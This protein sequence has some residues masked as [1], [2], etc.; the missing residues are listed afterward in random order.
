MQA[1]ILAAAV[2]LVLA[3]AP[4]AAAEGPTTPPAPAPAPAADPFARDFAAARAHLKG[5]RWKAARDALLRLFDAHRGSPAVLKSLPDIEE[6]LRLASFR[7]QEPEPT[8]E[9]IFGKGTVKFNARN[10]RIELDFPIVPLEPTWAVSE[11]GLG[12]LPIHFDEVSLQ[13]SGAASF[14]TVLY[15]AYD[16][17][18][19]T[20]IAIVPGVEIGDRYR[21]TSI[22]R[23][24]EGGPRSLATG[25]Y[26]TGMYEFDVVHKPGKV[27]YSAVGAGATASSPDIKGGIVA[28]KGATRGSLRLQGAVQQTQI[29]ALTAAHYERRFREWSAKSWDR[30]SMIP[31]WARKAPAAAASATA[32]QPALPFDGPEK[33]P[34][35]VLMALGLLEA[36]DDYAFLKT[37]PSPDGFRAASRHFLEGL[38]AMARGRLADAD[39]LLGGAVE[40]DPAFAPALVWRGLVRMRLRDLAGARADLE[41]ARSLA[42]EHALL[43]FALAQAHVLTGD[44]DGAVTVLHQARD[45]GA[46][47]TEEINLFAA[48]LARARRGPSWVRRYECRGAAGIVV[49]DH[50]ADM[51]KEVSRILEQTLSLCTTVFPGTVRPRVPIRVHVFSS[52]EGYLAYSDEVGRRLGWT[53]GA[54]MPHVREL[55]LWV[56][57]MGREDLWNTTRHEAFHAFL[58]DNLG[59]APIWFDEGWAQCFGAGKS[60]SGGISLGEIDPEVLEGFL[61]EG[62]SASPLRSLLEMDRKPF[63]ARAADHYAQAHAVVQFL[64]QTTKPPYRAALAEYFKSLR[65]G[66]SPSSAFEKHFEPLFPDLEEA[67]TSWARDRWRKSG[68]K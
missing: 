42:G 12:L 49:T 44:L 50:S 67:F 47:A 66:L 62:R 34:T 31:A 55:V 57:E 64:H 43:P 56:P 46:P 52:R 39:R 4:R 26:S 5:E 9:E 30:E 16:S 59:N 18:R 13:Y 36:G 61:G 58:H 2:G 3:A 7:A 29:H 40:R 20:G 21:N 41:K 48:Q 65:A 68:G 60:V 8:A 17:D 15:V 35:E 6:D 11:Q 37:L 54:Y 14:D 28:L 63:L 19:N 33:A 45:R 38:A 27:T 22:Q 23:V 32:V 25:G 24:G 10:R 53:A 1:R 51:A